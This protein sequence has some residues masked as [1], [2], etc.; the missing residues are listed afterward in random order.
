V[1]KRNFSDVQSSFMLRSPVLP[2]RAAVSPRSPLGASGVA[3]GSGGIH[4]ESSISY[5]RPD[6]LER[7][8]EEEI[9]HFFQAKNALHPISVVQKVWNTTTAP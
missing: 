3:G 5:S 8:S 1:R 4:S 9:K 6:D 2:R 7:P